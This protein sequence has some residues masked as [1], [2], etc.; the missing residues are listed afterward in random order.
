MT[1]KEVN[2]RLVAIFASLNNIE[3][4]GQNNVCN[5]AACIQILHDVLAGMAANNEAE[6]ESTEK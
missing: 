5:L 2:E 3:V 4:K 1:D 6:Q